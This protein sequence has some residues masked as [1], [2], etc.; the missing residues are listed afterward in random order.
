MGVTAWPQG[1]PCLGAAW[2][3]T[4]PLCQDSH[5]AAGLSLPVPMLLQPHLS[6]LPPTSGVGG[7]TAG[8]RNLILS[9]PKIP[10]CIH[11]YYKMLPKE[12]VRT[13]S[14]CPQTAGS[15]PFLCE[16]TTSNNPSRRDLSWHILRC[17]EDQL[18]ICTP[19][20]RK[21]FGLAYSN[22]ISLQKKATT[23]HMPY[24]L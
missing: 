3:V 20:M 1:C 18:T 16:N 21:V 6:A 7:G 22:L 10:F 4:G 23:P 17:S 13:G 8:R 24:F 12:R 11:L 9:F 19:R 2:R 15:S 5:G 14:L